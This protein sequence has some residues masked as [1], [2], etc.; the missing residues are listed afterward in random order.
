MSSPPRRRARG[1]GG[2]ASSSDNGGDR[3]VRYLG[4]GGHPGGGCG[5]WVT[6]ARW[7][8][9]RG[10]IGRSA[11]STALDSGP[12]RAEAP[13]DRRPD[14]RGL[15]RRH[16]AHEAC[17]KASR[18][19][20]LFRLSSPRR[21]SGSA[22][23]GRRRGLRGRGAAMENARSGGTASRSASARRLAFCPGPK[24][25]WPPVRGAFHGDDTHCLRPLQV[26]R[27]VAKCGGQ[28]YWAP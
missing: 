28:V 10:H 3:R 1:K 27:P 16:T 2:S 15:L 19:A 21:R 17:R 24:A 18:T 5:A 12:P 13:A 22:L 14:R 26:G 9:S 7:R 20:A 25:R 8:R 4:A 11:S 23:P 6:G